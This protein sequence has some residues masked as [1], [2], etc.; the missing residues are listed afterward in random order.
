MNDVPYFP[1][2]EEQIEREKNK[3]R[4]LRRTQWWKNR[5]A[6]GRCHYC[7]ARVHP[8]SLTMDHVVP[9]ARGGLTVRG[10]VVPCCKQC[11]TQKQSLLPLEWEQYLAW[12]DRDG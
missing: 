5:R 3:A 9:L 8:H 4:E 10:N 2:P 1:V 6:Q 11:N 12:L 7:G